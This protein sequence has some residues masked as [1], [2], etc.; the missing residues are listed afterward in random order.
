MNKIMML[1]M[2]YFVWAS[3]F[4]AADYTKATVRIGFSSSEGRANIPVTAYGYHSIHLVN[5]TKRDNQFITIFKTCFGVE[6]TGKLK[7]NE[8]TYFKVLKPGETYDYE[9][10][11][12]VT[13]TFYNFSKTEA[14]FAEAWT[15][16]TSQYFDG[17]NPADLLTMRHYFNAHEQAPIKI[18][19]S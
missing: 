1:I 19:K 10:K 7:C 6:R 11:T 9:F 4:A 15:M 17:T 16:I 18:N 8:N 12:N 5:E 14:H 13:Q 2:T 3:A